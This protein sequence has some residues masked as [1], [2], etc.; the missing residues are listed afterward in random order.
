LLVKDLE[1][2][3]SMNECFNP[4]D[5]RPVAGDHF[6]SWDLLGEHMVEEAKGGLDPTAMK[7]F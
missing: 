4:E 5:G 7:P 6:V 2:T 3:G 1:A